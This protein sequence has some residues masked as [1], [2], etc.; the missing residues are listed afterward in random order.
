MSKMTT[1]VK[2]QKAM[3]DNKGVVNFMGG[4]SYEINPLD[5]LKMVTASSI[6]GEPQYYRNGAFAEKTATDGLYTVDRLFADYSIDAL[7]KYKGMKTSELMEKVIDDALKYNYEATLLWAKTLRTEYLMR[8]N[9]QVIMVRAAMMTDARTAYTDANPGKF[10][11]INMAVMSRADDV[12]AQVTYYLFNTGDKKAIPGVLKRSW[13]KKVASLTRY[14]LYKYRN[15]GIGLIDTIRICHANNGDINEL[16]RTGTIDIEENNTTWE[17]LRACGKSWEEIL[18]TINMNHMALLRNLRGIFSEIESRAVL[19]K[20]LDALKGGVKKGKQFPFRYMSARNAV[21]AEAKKNDTLAKSVMDIDDALNDCL[22]IACENMPKLAGNNAFLSDNSGS[23]WGSFNSEYGSVTVAEIGNLSATIGAVNSDVGT[24]FAFGDRL[25]EYKISK[26]QGILTQA[27]EISKKSKREVGGGTEN[28]I[29][30]FFRDAI[31][32]KI[33]YDNIFV[34][35]DMQAGHGG[36]Y[37]TYE[38][39][40]EYRERGF[41]ANGDYVDVAKLIAEYRRTV[42]PKVNV[43]CVQT[44]G[45]N[46]VL[47]PEYGYRTNILYGWTGKELLFADAMNKFWDAKDAAKASKNVNVKGEKNFAQNYDV[48]SEINKK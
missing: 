31:D 19:T 43:F 44:A 13:A 23:A 12:I 34:Y 22:D 41:S 47:V 38:G 46:N 3:K 25:I 42:N 33:H 15:H 37:G 30:L 35:S 4:T 2:E 24:V 26:R 45:Y 11:E 36:L 48:K 10:A 39:K 29:W 21:R 1:A 16:M 32:K 6:F 14:E 7:D 17:T 27:E 8:L 18:E 40:K 9:P 28:G 5:T 20:M